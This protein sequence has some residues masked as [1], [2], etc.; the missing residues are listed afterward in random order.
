MSFKK[1]TK[2]FI[3]VFE[4]DKATQT[5]LGKNIPLSIEMDL[6]GMQDYKIIPVVKKCFKALNCVILTTV[7]KK[8][9]KVNL[10][11]QVRKYCKLNNIYLKELKI[12]D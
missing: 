10:M 3:V 5:G 7:H 9:D 11:N 4:Y 6:A 8:E 2:A 1:Q 12:E